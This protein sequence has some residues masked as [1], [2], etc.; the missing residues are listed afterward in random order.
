MCFSSEA[1]LIAG[2]VLLI[3][4]VA[5]IKKV[6]CQRDIPIALIPLLFALQQFT[7]GFLWIALENGDIPQTQ[8]WL[9]N[10]YGVFIGVIW[11]LYAS[12]A[13]YQG[14]PSVRRKRI[15]VFTGLVGLGLATYTI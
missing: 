6:R 3:T 11:P 4:G 9:T 8:F 12:F 10:I 5:T 1:S 14:E 13:V 7:E 15:I 2:G